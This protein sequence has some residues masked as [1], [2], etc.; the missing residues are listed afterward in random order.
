MPLQCNINAR[1]KRVRLIN[2][3]VTLAIGVAL[4][5]FWALPQSSPTGWTAAVILFAAGAFMIFE[6]LAGWC[7]PRAMGIRTKI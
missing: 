4:A 6:G 7:A 2:G 3:S 5:V 1:G